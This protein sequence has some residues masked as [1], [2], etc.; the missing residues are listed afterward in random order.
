MPSFVEGDRQGDVVV[1]VQDRHQAVVLEYEPNVAPS[2]DGQFVSGKGGDIVL[3]DSDRAC[4]GSIKTSNQ[5]HQG[6]F[7]GTGGSD[8]GDKFPL[9]YGKGDAFEGVYLV[10]AGSVYFLKLCYF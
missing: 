7:P 6:A 5:V 3:P 9:A 8:Y 4:C 10:Y 1:D 2:E